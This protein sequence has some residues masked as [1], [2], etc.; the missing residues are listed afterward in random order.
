M[1]KTYFL[2]QSTKTTNIIQV[3]YESSQDIYM[4]L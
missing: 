1:I 2:L 3:E 4:F